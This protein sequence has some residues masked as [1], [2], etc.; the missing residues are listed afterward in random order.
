MPNKLFNKGLLLLRTSLL[1]I[2][3]LSEFFGFGAVN[4]K[5]ADC[6]YYID[7]MWAQPDSVT[8]TTIIKFQATVRRD[9]LGTVCSKVNDMRFK[10]FVPKRVNGNYTGGT[11]GGY[12]ID[13]K[14]SFANTN[15][16]NIDGFQ[17]AKWTYNLGLFSDWDSLSDKKVF[18][19][20]MSVVPEN[21]GVGGVEEVNTVSWVKTLNVSGSTGGSGNDNLYDVAVD[22]DKNFVSQGDSF[23]VYATVKD[24]DLSSLP[25]TVAM[26]T[27]INGKQVGNNYGS[28]NNGI[29]KSNL[30]NKQTYQTV[31]VNANG[32]FTNGSNE[33]RV[34]IQDA[35]SP[36]NVY[37]RGTGNIQVSLASQSSPYVEI[38]P[39]KTNGYSVGDTIIITGKNFPQGADFTV[40]V[41]DKDYTLSAPNYTRTFTVSADQGFDVKGATVLSFDVTDK[42]NNQIDLPTTSFKVTIGSGGPGTGATTPG[43]GVTGSKCD[44]KDSN[45]KDCLYNPLPTGDLTTMFLWLARG[46]LGIIAIWGVIF[47][48]VGGF[49]MVMAQGNE[50]AYG[51][52]K[53]TITWAILGVIVAALSFSII[54]IVQNLIGADIQEAPKITQ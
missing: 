12:L 27:Y 30:K 3:L 20:A 53:K 10:F 45:S 5:A 49:R 11:I 50:E 44:G 18:E 17:D 28:N 9:G 46:F 19:Y 38:T 26:L 31:T 14:V 16:V 42:D 41:G 47:I 40:S 15:T 21:Y 13:Q 34:D 25:T 39:I 1:L 24:S 37:A 43:A 22:V 6:T 7:K 51:Q 29:Y 8:R 4:T 35:A 36:Y 33:I 48:I 52:A 54:A 23:K 2:F 32:P